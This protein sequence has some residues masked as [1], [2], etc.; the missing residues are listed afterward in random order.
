M[1]ASPHGGKGCALVFVA[2]VAST[3]GEVRWPPAVCVVMRLI[4]K[5]LLANAFAIHSV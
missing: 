4:T 2:S 3:Y 5:H 1:I